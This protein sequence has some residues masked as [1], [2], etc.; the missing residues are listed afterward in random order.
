LTRHVGIVKYEKFLKS[1]AISVPKRLQKIVGIPWGL[2]GG[3]AELAGSRCTCGDGCQLNGSQ[4]LDGESARLF[5]SADQLLD[6]FVVRFV[7]WKYD[8][9]EAKT[10]KT[11]QNY[12]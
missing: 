2:Q 5:N 11:Q 6:E 1:I 9:I 3:A 8:T 10:K 7:R 12:H 4:S